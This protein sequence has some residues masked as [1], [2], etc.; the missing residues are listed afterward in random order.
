M[1]SSLLSGEPATASG[2]NGSDASP[3]STKATA[4]RGRVLNEEGRPL[5]GATVVWKGSPY[6]VSTDAEGN[7][8]L[9]LAA[10]RSVILFSYVGYA[11]D[12]VTVRGGGTQNITL[13][14]SEQAPAAPVLAG[15][16]RRAQRG[17]K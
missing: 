15:G 6:G 1:S 5:V 11:D 8:L 3:A 2:S 7:Y 13:L 16:A 10:G 4:V 12:E 14:P 17:I 9:P